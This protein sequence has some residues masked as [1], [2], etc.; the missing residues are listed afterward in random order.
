MLSEN[1]ARMGDEGKAAMRGGAGGFAVLANGWVRYGTQKPSQ[2][3]Y[4]YGSAWHRD[5]IP[6]CQSDDLADAV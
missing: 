1:T 3:S 2:V 4:A 5:E 6:Q